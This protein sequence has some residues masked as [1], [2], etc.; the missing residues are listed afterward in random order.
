MNES[1]YGH[2][3][4]VGS[5]PIALIFTH[6]R[7]AAS[8]RLHLANRRTDKKLPTQLRNLGEHFFAEAEERKFN[9]IVFLQR[10]TSR[11][12]QHPQRWPRTKSSG[13]SS[14]TSSAPT[15]SN[16]PAT[17]L[18]SKTPPN[19]PSAATNTTLPVSATANPA[20]SPTPAMPQSVKTPPPAGYTSTS[21]PSS[22]HTCRTNGGRRSG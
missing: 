22:A 18:N 11:A 19:P 16:S 2:D 9:L 7:P 3:F 13:P 8:F 6:R 20:P 17:R 21:R 10:K 5:I 12:D 14:T 4:R 15:S 1:W